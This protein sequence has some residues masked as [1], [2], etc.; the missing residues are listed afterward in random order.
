MII[1]I[2]RAV[3]QFQNT[4]IN[5]FIDSLLLSIKCSFIFYLI[6]TTMFFDKLNQTKICLKKAKKKLDYGFNR[7][8]LISKVK[9]DFILIDSNVQSDSNTR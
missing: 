4:E 9:I 5:Q 3:Y 6:T 1:R 7:S 2:I 8:I